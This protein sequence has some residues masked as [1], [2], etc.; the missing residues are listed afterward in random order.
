MST[1]NSSSERHEGAQMIKEY[2]IN[3][4]Q[5][6]GVR[7]NSVKWSTDIASN[8]DTHVLTIDADPGIIKTK[9]SREQIEDYPRRVGAEK[10]EVKIREALLVG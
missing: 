2:C 8:D 6:V 7:L 3:Y 4:A 10:T 1:D 9:F 5:E